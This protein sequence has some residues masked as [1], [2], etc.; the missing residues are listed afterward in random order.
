MISWARY[1]LGQTQEVVDSPAELEEPVDV[2]PQPVVIRSPA[3]AEHS[4]AAPRNMIAALVLGLTLAG[5]AALIAYQQRQ[6]ATSLEEQLN[7]AKQAMGR[8]TAQNKTLSEQ[9]ANFQ[10][11]RNAL[12]ERVFSLGVQLSST[13]A[14]LKQANSRLAESKQFS[15]QLNEVQTKLEAQIASARV[16]REA[17]R[18]EIDRLRTEKAD[19]GRSLVRL[20]NQLALLERDYRQLAVQ[21][22]SLQSAPNPQ[23]GV[24]S[25]SGVSGPTPLPDSTVGGRMGTNRSSVELPP[26]IVPARQTGRAGTIQG[27]VVDVNERHRFIVVDKGSLD[28]VR[29]GMAF[30][31]LRGNATV[32]RATAIRLRPQLTACGLSAGVAAGA[33]KVGD[34]V[35]QQGP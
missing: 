30:D 32:G 3:K 16:E 27:R 15:Q 5:A 22:A 13:A 20:R 23:L 17:A 12:D 33:L 1:V 19:V 25:S 6:R 10:A 31:I 26:V 21:M 35:T 34:T 2:A 11:E 7:L 29:E 28:G 4:T 14:E 9:L 18:E 24:V 8:L